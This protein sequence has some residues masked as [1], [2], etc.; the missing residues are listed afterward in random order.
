MKNEEKEL[1]LKDLSAR[2]PYGVKVCN[3][4]KV[5]TLIGM[6]KD[7]IYADGSGFVPCLVVL[8]IDSTKP[9]LRPMSSMTEEEKAYIR[10]VI[11]P[12]NLD[13]DNVGSLATVNNEWTLIPMSSIEEYMD[14]LL[15]KHLDYRGLISRDL[16]LEA[17][18]D[19]YK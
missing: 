7:Q 5:Y 18:A 3:N 14:F 1:L 17:P 10:R 12:R 19:M 13:V 4:K 2:L 8:H 15:K 16:A 6:G 11:L 9:Y